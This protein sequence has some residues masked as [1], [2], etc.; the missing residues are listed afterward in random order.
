MLA[1]LRRA[2]QAIVA[3]GFSESQVM[4]NVAGVE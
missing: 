1:G 2:A 4:E 3:T